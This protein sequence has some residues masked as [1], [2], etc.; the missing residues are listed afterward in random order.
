MSTTNTFWR[1][2]NHFPIVEN[3]LLVSKEVTFTGNNETAVV[4]LFTVTGV[5]EVVALYGVVK[6]TFGA[7]HT[8]A[9]WRV[10][11]QTATDQIL[12]K[13]TTLNLSG[14]SPNALV[15]KSGLITAAA[16]YKTADA[17]SVYE[18]TTLQTHVFTPAIIVQKTSDIQTDIEYVYTTTDTPTSGAM[19][20]YCGFIPLSPDGNVVAY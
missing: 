1:D 5:V 16:T 12:T 14:I 19:T 20:F 11:D 13:A 7:N 6:T 18:P 8:D 2:A 4:P 10:N 17:A 9:H 3:G 15:F